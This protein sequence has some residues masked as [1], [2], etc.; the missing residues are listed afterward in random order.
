MVERVKIPP[1]KLPK[2][3][4]NTKQRKLNVQFTEVARKKKKRLSRKKK[5]IPMST[6]HAL[7]DGWCTQSLAVACNLQAEGC[8]QI[9]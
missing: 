1:A 3:S 2:G 5:K 4:C 7:V 6:V 9:A 8:T